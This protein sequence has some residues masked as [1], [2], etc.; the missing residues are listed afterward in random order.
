M[1]IP[2]N[3]SGS[4]I[5]DPVGYDDVW[6]EILVTMDKE[7][8]FSGRLTETRKIQLDHSLDDSVSHRLAV[9]FLNKQD[10]DTD[11][12]NNRDKAVVINAIEF[13]GIESP[14]F[15]WAGE[16]RPTY[17]THMKSQPA[18]LKYQNYLGWNGVWYLDFTVPIFTWIHQVED[19]GWIYD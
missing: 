12:I 13:F 19:L 11:L 7:L 1:A 9:E 4:L 2:Y 15:V 10:T 14:R 17:P 3:L 5:I 8:L 18:I 6:P 16:Y